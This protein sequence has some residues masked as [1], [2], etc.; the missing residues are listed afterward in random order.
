[1]PVRYYT[2]IYIYIKQVT[3]VL[4]VFGTFESLCVGSICIVS[5]I[6]KTYAYVD[7]IV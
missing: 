3:A 7:N 1:M 5:L 6:N 2:H 4:T